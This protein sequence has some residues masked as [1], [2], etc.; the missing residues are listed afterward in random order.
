MALVNILAQLA[1]TS[2]KGQEDEWARGFALFGVDSLVVWV[3]VGWSRCGYS[4]F[5]TRVVSFWGIFIVSKAIVD[6]AVPIPGLFARRFEF[7]SHD[8]PLAGGIDR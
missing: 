4:A 5:A 2:M 8:W 7:L 1:K 3:C 6:L